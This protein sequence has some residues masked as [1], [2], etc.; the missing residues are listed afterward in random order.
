MPEALNGFKWRWNFSVP[1]N[2]L[3]KRSHF[4]FDLWC[5]LSCK[6]VLPALY[7]VHLWQ[8]ITSWVTILIICVTDKI[9]HYVQWS[10][11]K[12]TLP[13]MLYFPAFPVHTYA[14]IRYHHRYLFLISFS[15]SKRNHPYTLPCQI[16][17]ARCLL[18][19]VM[20]CTPCWFL[21]TMF[22]ASCTLWV[23]F[24]PRFLLLHHEILK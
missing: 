23:L 19:P 24:R 10:T 9:S 21:Q 2:T 1:C 4:C 8:P 13:N 22:F 17:T 7:D 6:L 14:M 15:S 12:L 5:P 11:K 16:R 18:G 20:K 3:H